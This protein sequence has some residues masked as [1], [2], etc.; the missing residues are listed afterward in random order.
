MNHAKTS[1]ATLLLIVCSHVRPPLLD[2]KETANDRQAELTD[3]FKKYVG[4]NATKST[5]PQWTSRRK[6]IGRSDR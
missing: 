5:H 2:A 1:I 4:L 3:C 6:N